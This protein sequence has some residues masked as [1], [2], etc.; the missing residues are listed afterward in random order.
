VNVELEESQP[1]VEFIFRDETISIEDGYSFNELIPFVINRDDLLNSEEAYAKI[2]D[3]AI[4]LKN[5]PQVNVTIIANTATD[6]PHPSHR[7]G[8]DEETLSSM[9]EKDSDTSNRLSLPELMIARGKKI[10]ELLIEEGVNPDQLSYK[11]GAHHMW[12]Y[13]RYVTFVLNGGE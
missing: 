13:Q 12:K 3:L 10:K 9:W 8:S 7:Y 4:L 1:Q 11:Q 6:E 2:Q 5:Y